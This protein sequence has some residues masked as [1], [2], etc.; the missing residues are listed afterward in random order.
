M[1][2]GVVNK[3]AE[4]KKG[5]EL[6]GNLSTS[7]NQFVNVTMMTVV[8][9]AILIG[10]VCLALRELTDEEGYR[11]MKWANKNIGSSIRES[12]KDVWHSPP[13]RIVGG[14]QSW[15]GEAGAARPGDKQE[16]K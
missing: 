16:Q 12:G 14:M 2:N 5:I 11:W 4:I 6:A 10:R 3:E 9:L 8:G 15:D 13:D 1:A 7:F